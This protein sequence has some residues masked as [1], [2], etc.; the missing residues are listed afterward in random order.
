MIK[1]S[2]LDILTPIS[3]DHQE[4]LGKTLKKITNEKLGIIKKTSSIII[5]KQ[6]EEIK[7][8][9]FTTRTIFLRVQKI[10]L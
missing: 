8:F 9:Y 7:N 5:G 1:N 10:I 6:K 2:I 4:H 3:Y